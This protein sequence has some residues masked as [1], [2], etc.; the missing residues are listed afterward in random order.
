LDLHQRL[1]A[2]R[3][4]APPQRLPLQFGDLLVPRVRELRGWKF[5]PSMRHFFSV[6]LG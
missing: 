6:I 2:L 3:A 1:G 4:L 5:S